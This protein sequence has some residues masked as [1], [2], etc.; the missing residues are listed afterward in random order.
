MK[1]IVLHK[2]GQPDVLN[3]CEVPIPEVKSGWVL[4]KVKAFGIN[5]SE[6]ILRQFEGNASYIQLPR[7][8]GIECAGEVA[9]PSDTTLHK[10]QRV[11]ALMGGMGRAFTAV[12]PNTLCCPQK[13]SL[14]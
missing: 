10:G 6:L 3:V 7:I 11:V 1:A 14:Q 2:T 5:H 4:V 9:D 12:M 8:I 13:T